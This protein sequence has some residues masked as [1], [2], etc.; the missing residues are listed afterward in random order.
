MQ[1]AYT[2]HCTASIAALAHRLHGYKFKI[3]RE[4]EVNDREHTVQ[5]QA[6]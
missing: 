1:G 3:I 4:G 5:G 6:V 2:I